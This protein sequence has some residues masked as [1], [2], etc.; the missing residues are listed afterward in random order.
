MKTIDLTKKKRS[1]SDIFALA[2]TEPL[3]I[4][5]TS[6]EDFLVERADDF[7]R[8]VAALGASKS[9]D[10]FLKARSGE[11][12]DIPLEDVRKKHET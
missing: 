9:F 4:H 8:E 7:D 11:T 5:W 12:G 1:L 10:S 3:L 2:K 6:G